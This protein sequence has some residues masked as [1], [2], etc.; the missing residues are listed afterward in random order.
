MKNTNLLATIVAGITLLCLWLPAKAQKPC[1]DDVVQNSLWS[2]PNLYAEFPDGNPPTLSSLPIPPDAI[3]GDDYMA[4]EATNTH[5]AIHDQNGD[6]LF[7]I[8]DDGLY[9]KNGYGMAKL[10]LNT[11]AVKGY[12]EVCI[13]PDPAN[14]ERYYIFSSTHSTE[15]RIPAYSILDL[16][17]PNVNDPENEDKRGALIDGTFAEGNFK[18]IFSDLSLLDVDSLQAFSGPHYSYFFAASPLIESN[19]SRLLFMAS[20][21]GHIFRMRIDHN[22]IEQIWPP[23]NFLYDDNILPDILLQPP[24][25][26]SRFELELKL[27]DSTFFRLGTVMSGNHTSS[28]VNYTQIVLSVDLDLDGNYIPN[29]AQGYPMTGTGSDFP[30]VKG[31][32]YSQNGRYL[33]FTHHTNSNFPDAVQYLDLDTMQTFVLQIPNAS[34]YQRSQIEVGPDSL[35]YFAHAGGLAALQSSNYPFSPWNANAITISGGYAES[36][37]G[38]PNEWFRFA[39]TM[40]NQIDGMNYYDHFFST[41]A[42]CLIHPT[43]DKEEFV[44]DASATW[45]GLDNPLRPEPCDTI[46]IRDQLTIP[47]GVHITIKNM[48]FEFFE[49]ARVVIEPGGRLTLD[50]TIFTSGPCGCEMW[51]G[52]EVHGNPNL[53]QSTVNQGFLETRNNSIIEHAY[54]GVLAG[55][56]DDGFDSDSHSFPFSGGVIRATNSRFRNNKR[57]VQIQDYI[58]QGGS[59]QIASNFSSFTNCDF[60]TDGLLNNADVFPEYHALLTKVSRVP[61]RNCSFRNTASFEDMPIVNRGTGIFADRATFQVTGNNQIYEPAHDALPISDDV[62]QAFYQLYY[63]VYV[64]GQPNHSFTVS[65]MEFQ[66]NKL[67]IYV[68]GACYE[69]ITFNNFKIPEVDDDYPGFNYGA[70]LMN[71]YLFTVEEN[72]FFGGPANTKIAGLVVDNS[73]PD[74]AEED[75]IVLENEVYRNTFTSL[76]IGISVIN[77]NRDQNSE[78]GLQARCNMFEYNHSADIALA[79]YSEWRK[80]QGE[81]NP[82]EAATNNIFSLP[83][84]NCGSIYRDV[85]VSN[86]YG[87]NQIPNLLTI[88]Y[89]TLQNPD[90]TK[91]WAHSLNP[92]N[93]CV[94]PQLVLYDVV[95]GTLDYENH[96]RSNFNINGGGKYELAEVLDKQSVAEQNLAS[97]K[98]VYQATIDG[99][100]TEDII[101]LL[102]NIFDEE[103]AYLRDLLLARYPLSPEAL[104]AAIDAAESFDPWHL[105]Q[106]LV[107]NSKLPGDVYQFLKDNGVLSSFFMQF[108]DDAQQNGNVSL[109]RLLYSEISWRSYEKSQAERDIHR[110]YLHHSDSVDAIAWNDYINSR[111]EAY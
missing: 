97:A 45:T 66:D 40:P 24:S 28:S 3:P 89:H 42:C 20:T 88:D 87:A 111:P 68:L 74:D 82:P 75:D 56:R 53:N 47:E 67:G 54:I 64:T 79:P 72:H 94:Q 69:T 29:S 34:N 104:M 50:S 17:L 21:N 35:L 61:F 12:S 73:C 15:E 49:D 58:W 5:N 86:L 81:L 96:C 95:S 44:A 9:D 7:F 32:E 90:A 84:Y 102:Q 25:N 103:S 105:T 91:P 23:L 59:G 99:G 110:L 106:V 27:V 38:F 33:Y 78:V 62:H 19:N 70:Y 2:L 43:Y 100:D 16:S 60:L 80:N 55:S 30:Y 8:V 48:R 14:C 1:T 107:A 63:G 36:Q 11:T 10:R 77:D 76:G 26:S 46:Q 92:D 109:A 18:N 93:D 37:M 31:L 71:S 4:E 13:V 83:T 108:V 101:D 98:L 41:K 85:K 39:Y 52:V 51:L 6:L 57:D 22:G 65:K